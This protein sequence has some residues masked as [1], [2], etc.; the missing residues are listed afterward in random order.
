MSE[1]PS[2][3]EAINTELQST[4]VEADLKLKLKCQ[5]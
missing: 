2:Q 3:E 1:K 4:K 5:S